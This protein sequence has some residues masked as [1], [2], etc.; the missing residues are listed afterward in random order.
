ML[1][2]LLPLV[3]TVA[4]DSIIGISTIGFDVSYGIP[5]LLK[6]IYNYDNFPPTQMSLGV[7]SNSLNILS[8]VW[9]FGTSILLL[10][11]T[12]SPVTTSSMNYT[13]VVVGGF[14]ALSAVYWFTYAKDN[15]RGPSKG[16]SDVSRE[17]EFDPLL[18]R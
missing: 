17:S 9:L 7:Y 6:V 3:S 16:K 15:F 1:L 5:I 14:S 4:F 2:L 13:V 12:A 18:M 10:L 8:V 11:P